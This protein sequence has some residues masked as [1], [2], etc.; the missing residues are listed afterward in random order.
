MQRCVMPHPVAGSEPRFSLFLI[1]VVED[2]ADCVPLPRAQVANSM[3]QVNPIGTARS[4]NR[5]MM[6]CERYAI[7]LP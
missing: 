1:C 3:P 2:N 5:T 6:H 4:L 7:T